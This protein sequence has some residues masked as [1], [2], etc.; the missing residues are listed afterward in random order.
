M[1]KLAKVEGEVVVVENNAK[2][3]EFYECEF[4]L[5]DSVES[6]DQARQ[7][8]QAGKI[9]EYLKRNHKGFKRWRTCQVV[10]LKSVPEKPESEELDGLMIQAQNLGCLPDNIDNYKRP[11]YK[12]K[13]VE[14]SI[15]A[16]KS[17]E[18]K[19]K[20]KKDQNVQDM[21]YVD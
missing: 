17:R 14:K 18:A 16:H 19:K 15:A 6:I 11:D 20:A 8:I 12:L 21:G 9:T 1:G 13:A 3:V 2:S 10:E 5:A 7:L 4:I